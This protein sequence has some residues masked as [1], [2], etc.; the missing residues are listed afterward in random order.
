M[1]TPLTKKP[2]EK[3]FYYIGEQTSP[4]PSDVKNFNVK[5]YTEAGVNWIE[6]EACLHMFEL[7]GRNVRQ[8]LGDNI[9]S[10]ICKDDKIQSCLKRNGWYGEQNH[11]WAIFEGQ[12]LTRKRVENVDPDRRSH[13]ILLP[14]REK[15]ELWANIQNA[16]GSV[17]GDGFRKEIIQGLIPVF[18]CRCFGELVMHGGKPTVLCGKVTTYDWVFYPGFEGASMKKGTERM[19]HASVPFAESA[20]TE[21]GILIAVSDIIDDIAEKDGN[22][23]Q[24]LEFHELDT[25]S[26]VGVTQDKKHSIVKIDKNSYV[27]PAMSEES[28]SMVHDFYRSFK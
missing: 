2:P 13:K 15:N 18:S 10:L 24:F 11:P 14:R 12:K 6:F 28:V 7:L 22:T 19:K 25:D 5:T 8:Y 3:N 26:V 9:W 17:F 20:E 4:D 21:S 23:A 1:A 16:S 27:Y